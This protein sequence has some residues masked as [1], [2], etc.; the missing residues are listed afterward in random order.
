MLR[1]RGFKEREET[2]GEKTSDFIQFH[3]DRD[4]DQV[5]RRLRLNEA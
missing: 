3:D 1:K 4:P 2:K 5:K